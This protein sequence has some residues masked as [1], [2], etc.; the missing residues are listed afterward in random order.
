MV[1][2]EGRI[3]IQSDTSRGNKL[4]KRM[5]FRKGRFK[6][7]RLSK[8]NQESKNKMG[9]IRLIAGSAS[10]RIEHESPMPFSGK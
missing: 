10:E 4:K 2:L 6:V 9:G 5:Q 1:T 3:R 7:W 8:N